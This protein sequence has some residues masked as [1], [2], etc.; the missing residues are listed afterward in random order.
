MSDEFPTSEPPPAKRRTSLLFPG[1]AIMALLA[2]AAW[3][4]W[5]PT[6]SLESS[7]VV[8][9]AAVVSPENE[10][11]RAE[12]TALH[13]RLEDAAKVNRS[14]RE[15]V[16][17][18]TQRVGLL[19]D[20]LTSLER[21]A[22][23]G[24]DAL[25][26]VEADYLLRLGEERLAL[27]GDVGAARKAFELADAQLAQASDPGATAVRQTLAL[28]RD[29]LAGVQVADLPVLLARLGAL[30]DEVGKWQLKGVSAATATPADAA[31]GWWGRAANS[32][33]QYFRVRRVDPREQL[34]GG[35]LLR[36]RI[37]LELARARMLLLRGEGAAALPLIEGVRREIAA[38]FAPEDAQVL[39]ALSVLDEIRSAPLVPKLPALGES[40]RELA[41]LRDAV[42]GR[43]PV[44]SMPTP[45]LSPDASAEASPEAPVESSQVPAEAAPDTDSN[46]AAPLPE[47]A[48]ADPATPPP[49]PD[50]AVPFDPATP[51]P[52]Q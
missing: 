52:E 13:S 24:L 45:E 20:G 36:E 48:P 41:R 43:A 31:P 51:T 19:E 40:R 46:E 34:R 23:P 18:L 8:E 10:R 14:L 2:A 25:R 32:F 38:N 27:F 33:D 6:T 50:T 5:S 1:L 16:L 21:G 35:P 42:T 11:I 7:P 37:A 26:L 17:G 47:P 30:A 9:P 44:D 29:A 49:V 4:R 22:A 12:L 15:Q 3:Y 28:E 39:R